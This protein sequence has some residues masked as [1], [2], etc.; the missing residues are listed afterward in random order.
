MPLQFIF[1][2]R[3][4]YA[5]LASTRLP[6]LDSAIDYQPIDILAVMQKVN[7]R[8]SPECPAKARYAMLDADRWARQYNV[9]MR[10]NTALMRAMGRKT[11]DGSLLSRAGL[12]A[13]DLG[14]FDRA[15]PAL[16]E[17]VWASDQDLLSAEG[18]AEFLRSRDIDADIWS[19]AEAPNI[20]DQ[21]AHNNEDAAVRGVFGVPSFFVDTELFFG[22]DRLDFVRAA[23]LSKSTQEGG[24]L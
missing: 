15:H 2:Y 3:S 23:L 5:Y 7:N 16:F 14:V 21:L 17:A 18:R 10:P 13:R 4:P 11:F 1:D 8:P 20:H 22:N 24:H 6:S 9:P 12:A 19:R